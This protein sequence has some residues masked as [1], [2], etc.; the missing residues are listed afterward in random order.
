KPYREAG[1]AAYDAALARQI[2]P[3]RPDL[4]VLAGWMRILTPAF[5]DEFPGK[6]INLHPALPGQFVGTH[7]IERAYEAYRRGEIEH[8]GCMVH[9]VVPEVDAG[10]VVGTAV[11]P[12]YPDDTLAGFEARMHAAEHKLIVAAVRQVI[13]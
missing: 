13:E 12:L 10:P 11:V 5:L 7:A 8:S 3:Y 1:R 2:A 6:I 4:V 9:Y